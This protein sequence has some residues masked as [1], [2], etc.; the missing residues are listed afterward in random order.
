MFIKSR[1]LLASAACMLTLMACSSKDAVQSAAPSKEAVAATVDGIPISESLV[2]LM[3]KQRSDMGRDAGAEARKT[4]IDRL[5]MQLI[6]SQAAIKEGL[7]KGPEVAD[8]I[9]LIK[10]SVLVDAFV[11]NYFKNNPVSDDAVNAAYAKMKA[12]TTGN[13]YKARHILVDNEAEA[14]DII[15]KLNKNPKAFAALAKEKSKDGASKNNGGELGWFDPRGMIP[16]F[17]AAVAKLAKGKFTQEPVKTQFGYHV[18]L[19]EDSRPL[20]V[21][22]LEQVKATLTQQLQQQNLKKLFDEMK[23]KAKIEITQAPAPAPAPAQAAKPADS[24]KK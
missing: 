4:Y 2:N 15:A 23:A 3:L 12:E 10:Q 7:D 20:P 13:E 9:D 1:I 24:T 19:L 5:A 14:K 11:K 8:Q 22:S 6:I 17:G 16:E 18:I 21:P